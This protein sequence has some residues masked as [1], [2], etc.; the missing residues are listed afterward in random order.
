MLTRRQGSQRE[1]PL[2]GDLVTGLLHFVRGFLE[3]HHLLVTLVYGVLK[4]GIGLVR[5]LVGLEVVN[6]HVDTKLDVGREFAV[7]FGA[8]FGGAENELAGA[9]LLCRHVL[10]LVSKNQ[11]AGFERL[12]AISRDLQTRIDDAH[13]AALYVLDDDVQ[14]IQARAQRNRFLIDGLQRKRAVEKGV[15]K[16]AADGIFEGLHHPA[17][18]RADAAKNIE[19]GGMH[20]V[21]RVKRKL[22]VR[23]LYG[24]GNQDGVVGDLQ[25]IGAIGEMHLVAHDARRDKRFQF[26]VPALPRTG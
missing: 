20:A 21:L 18:E 8:N 5:L 9:N 6:L 19:R 1:Q 14:A 17:G 2:D 24:D 11:R 26:L 13:V 10:Q 16:I 15:W 4:C 12:V 23:N 25:K 3:P 22:I 7:Q